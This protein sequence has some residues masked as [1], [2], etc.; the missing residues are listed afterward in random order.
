M[1]QDEQ[2]DVYDDDNNNNVR[3]ANIPPR[4]GYCVYVGINTGQAMP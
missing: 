3:M 4:I 1:N 2:D